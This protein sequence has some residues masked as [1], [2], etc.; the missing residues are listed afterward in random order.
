MRYN[1]HYEAIFSRWGIR[2]KIADFEKDG[3]IDLEQVLSVGGGLT[4]KRVSKALLIKRI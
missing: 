3:D 2:A 1:H 4:S